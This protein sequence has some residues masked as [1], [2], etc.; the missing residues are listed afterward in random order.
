MAA[1][2]S[3]RPVLDRKAL[4]AA[5]DAYE[6][7]CKTSGLFG[8]EP[9]EEDRSNVV[10]LP[11]RD[12]PFAGAMV[13]TSTMRAEASRKSVEQQEKGRSWNPFADM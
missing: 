1:V 9:V 13:T 8:A 7:L 2:S 10:D 6:E 11:R 3:W 5:G 12:D 4:A